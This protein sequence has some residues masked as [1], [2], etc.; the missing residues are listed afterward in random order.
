MKSNQELRE[1][2]GDAYRNVGDL[3][4]LV[5]DLFYP[6]LL[7]DITALNQPKPQLIF[8]L[9]SWCE[10]EGRLLDLV[11]GA[12]ERKQGN[13]RLQAVTAALRAALPL[14]HGQESA[15]AGW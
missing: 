13:P 10:S 9:M 14:G 15:R 12:Y 11:L 3:E 4:I 7:Q 8:Q 1:A 2:I 6:T 5:N